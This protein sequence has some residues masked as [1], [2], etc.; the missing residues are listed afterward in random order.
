MFSKESLVFIIGIVLTILPFL[1]IPES[2]RFLG[3]S[4]G[5][6]ILVFVGYTL[7]RS[8]YL[9]KIDHGNGERGTDSFVETTETLFK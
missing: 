7:R 3:T 5:G 1:G 8:V 9:E 6:I 2:W 4:L